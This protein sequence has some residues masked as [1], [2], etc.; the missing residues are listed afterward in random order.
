[1]RL[2][3]PLLNLINLNDPLVRCDCLAVCEG[4]STHCQLLMMCPTIFQHLMIILML[5]DDTIDDSNTRI[6]FS[7]WI[8]WHE[9]FFPAHDDVMLSLHAK[10]L[11][12]STNYLLP[13]SY[14]SIFNYSV[15]DDDLWFTGSLHKCY[16]YLKSSD[17]T[18]FFSFCDL[19][20]S[21]SAFPCQ[22]CSMIR[23]LTVPTTNKCRA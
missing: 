6:S 13:A 4:C 18:L 21:L 8:W 2:S 19:H 12:L 1:M 20:V 9:Y 11:A 16:F 14:P 5:F 3:V 7:R 10:L 22:P 23:S 15:L 17:M